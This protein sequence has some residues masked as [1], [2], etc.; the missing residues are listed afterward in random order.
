MTVK[1]IPKPYGSAFRAAC[2]AFDAAAAADTRT[3]TQANDPADAQ[4]APD[5][6]AFAPNAG[7][8]VGIF[9]PDAAG[10]LGVK[11]FYPT[12]TTTRTPTDSHTDSHTDSQ[13]DHPTTTRVDVAPYVRRLFA[14]TPMCGHPPGL[15][16]ATGR[17]VR[18]GI[19][20]AGRVSPTVPLCLGTDDAPVDTILS[21]APA[22]VAIRPGER[23]ELSVVTGGGGV[24]ATFVF[25]EGAGSR[26]HYLPAAEGMATMVVSPE[27]AAKQFAALTGRPAAELR[28]FAVEL[29]LTGAAA[30]GDSGATDP[31]SAAIDSG[32]RNLRRDYL[33]E[34]TLREG[35]R[36]AWVNRFG[37]VDYHTFPAAT[38]RRVAGSR[39]RIL[40]E[41]GYRTVATAAAV[42]ETLVGE[43]CD[44]ATAQ[45]LAEIHS[46][47]AVWRVGYAA[48]IGEGGLESAAAGLFESVDEGVDDF[49]R[50][51]AAGGEVRTSPLHPGSVTV[52]ISPA[53]NNVSR[54]L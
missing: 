24:T 6:L 32:R 21:A 35:V 16:E 45:W 36:L 27:D 1:D 5:A 13:T 23:D 8:D 34:P 47:P 15:H 44:A 25:P 51:E 48:D 4:S 40:S 17:V 52:T 30:G 41:G 42:S 19:E 2:F 29:T 9:S 50:V 39:L 26:V 46:S 18:C 22:R 10:R 31:G 28:Q 49:E 33:L 12:A 11:R 7:I 14:P 3:A 54:K 43:P 53:T 37:A 20:V 38:E